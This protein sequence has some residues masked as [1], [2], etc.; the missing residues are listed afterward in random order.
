[1]LKVACLIGRF[2][3]L[4]E[5]TVMEEIASVEA[6]GV[7]PMI[8]ACR[9]SNEALPPE[10]LAWRDKVRT[11]DAGREGG[12]LVSL[13]SAAA[14]AAALL[15]APG[16]LGCRLLDL[17]PP[18]GWSAPWRRARLFAALKGSGA[19]LLHAEFGH[20]GLLALPVAEQLGL[21]LV[22]SFRGQD[23]LLVRRAR[24]SWRRTFFKRA[25]LLMARSEEMRRDLIEM[26]FPEANVAVH[27]SCI[28]VGDIPFAERTPPRSE[29]ETVILMAGRMAPKKGMPDGLRAFAAC[30][31]GPRVPQL[32]IAGDG[33]QRIELERLARELGVAE[34]VTFLGAMPRTE[35]LREMQSAHLFMLPCRTAPDGEKEGIPNVLKEAQATGLP[36]LSTTH[37]GIPEAVADGESGLLAPEGDA[38]AL[39]RRLGDLLADPPRWAAM[40]RR[41]RELMEERFDSEKLAPLLAAHYDSVVRRAV[42]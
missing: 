36:V 2:P 12:P 23:V 29:E 27:P 32:R 5:H 7:E 15:T 9:L 10:F 40:G 20:L 21:P 37:A 1:V 30:R 16:G 38:D 6:H 11:L 33:P 3:A 18:L 19:Q 4:T 24:A 26:G 17:G 42:K 35:L 25:A 14:G 8:I 39:A 28:R 34:R 31:P 13:R 41:G 22:V